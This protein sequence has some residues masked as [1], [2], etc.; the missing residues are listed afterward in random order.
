[1]NVL[2]SGF[3]GAGK[4]DVA[5]TL[6]LALNWTFVS[7]SKVREAAYQLNLREPASDFWRFS[8][9][10]AGLD[11]KRISMPDDD[12]AV[13]TRLVKMIAAST[14]CVFDVWFVPW[15][16]KQN[17]SIRIWLD[18]PFEVRLGRVAVSMHRSMSQIRQAVSEKDKRAIEFARI[19][20]A[21]DMAT[22]RT[23]F[24]IV[25]DASIMSTAEIADA[26]ASIVKV[27]VRAPGKPV[28]EMPL[29]L[30]IGISFSS[31]FAARLRHV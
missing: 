22:D 29:E 11:L 25:V 31:M 6:A 28:G 9:H 7:G 8:D 24:D 20:Y 15:L 13:D 19:A 10:S 16:L 23:P 1:V 4:T 30:P 27:T 14:N 18:A 2:I 3:T 21:I 5:T 17:T 26:L 12:K